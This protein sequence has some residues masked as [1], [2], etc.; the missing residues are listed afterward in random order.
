MPNGTSAMASIAI[1]E[2]QAARIADYTKGGLY[3]DQIG[4]KA[5]GT[6]K[7]QAARMIAG[8]KMRQ[9]MARRALRGQGKF[10]HGAGGIAT[11]RTTKGGKANLKQFK[12]R[13]AEFT[14]A[15]RS[16]EAYGAKRGK[17]AGYKAHSYS[18]MRS[19]ANRK[20]P[21]MR[22]ALRSKG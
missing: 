15:Y 16:G 1:Q 19:A 6:L 11:H 22:Q 7:S 10:A 12:T 2:G 20:I 3:K 14:A 13:E 4:K 5:A 8:M 9:A 18:P 21:T 17:T